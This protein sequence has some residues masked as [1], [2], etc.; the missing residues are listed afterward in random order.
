MPSPL[1]AARLPMLLALVVV[2]LPACGDEPAGTPQPPA[3]SYELGLESAPKINQGITLADD[4][5]PTFSEG[6]QHAWSLASLFGAA[7]KRDGTRLEA[8]DAEGTKTDI[9]RPFRPGSGLVWVLRANK[10]GDAQL[11]LVDPKTPFPSFH[12]RGG[13]R[14][15]AGDPAERRVRNVARL[16][17]VLGKTKPKATPTGDEVKKQMTLQLRVTVDGEE[18]T[19]TEE[20]LVEL[21][22]LEVEGDSGKGTRDAWSARALTRSL[23]GDTARLTEVIGRGGRSLV[24]HADD[25]GNDAKV[26][27]L[28]LNRRGQFKFHWADKALQPTPDPDMRDVSGLVIVTR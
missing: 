1:R 14:G 27:L 20:D 19:L 13:N 25:W 28:R 7:A 15:R 9:E 2:L 24:V 17:L 18:R 12:G 26:P 8:Y 3:I 22:P 23:G 5:Q 4:L 16:R 6:D 11:T 10:K 21:D